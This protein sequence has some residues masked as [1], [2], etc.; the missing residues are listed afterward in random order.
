MKGELLVTLKES[1]AT[2]LGTNKGWSLTSDENDPDGQ[3]LLFEY[4][5]IEKRVGYVQQSVKIEMGARSEHWPVIERPI[6]SYVKEALQGKVVEAAVNVRVLKAERTFW[7]KATILHQY[8]HFPEGK[9]LPPRI[10]RHFYDFFCLLNSDVKAHALAEVAL[11]ER[12][13]KHKNVYF[14][15]AW[16][17]YETARKG[18]LKLSPLPR[19]Q[20]DLE[21]DFRLMSQMFFGEMPAW[22][23]ILASIR[24][25]EA[26]FNA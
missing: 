18:A 14:A 11:L 20:E 2:E 25:F 24:H 22:D 3:T 5:A 1:I 12:V 8:A 7:E 16:A 21:K 6:Q 19:V 26:E 10:S 23:S 13:A 9:T 15:S 17:S 4:P